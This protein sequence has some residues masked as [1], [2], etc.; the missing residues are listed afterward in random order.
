MITLI[1]RVNYPCP[2]TYFKIRPQKL[3]VYKYLETLE[4]NFKQI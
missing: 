2:Y 3:K 4:E 1:L